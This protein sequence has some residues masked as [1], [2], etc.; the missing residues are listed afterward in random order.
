M[1]IPRYPTPPGPSATSVT[2]EQ[3][4]AYGALEAD[5]WRRNIS[6]TAYAALWE[7]TDG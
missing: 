3:R 1:E 7:P 6:H 5:R 2:M 4:A